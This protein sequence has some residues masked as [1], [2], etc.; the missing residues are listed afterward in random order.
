MYKNWVSMYYMYKNHQIIRGSRMLWICHI[1]VLISTNLWTHKSCVNPTLSLL[2][3]APR[4]RIQS[5]LHCTA[6]SLHIFYQ[7]TILV[8][9]YIL[10]C[11]VPIHEQSQS[12]PISSILFLKKIIIHTS[13]WNRH[14]TRRN[15]SVIKTNPACPG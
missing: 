8:V 9:N 1:D 10:F 14:T 6:V 2:C 7:K 4:C 15:P 11:N 13:N 5:Y 12:Q 3:A